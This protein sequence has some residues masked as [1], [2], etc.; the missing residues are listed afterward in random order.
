MTDVLGH[1]FTTASKVGSRN[2]KDY[3]ALGGIEGGLQIVKVLTWINDPGEAIPLNRA[4]DK[5]IAMSF[6][7]PG[8]ESSVQV[9]GRAMKQLTCSIIQTVLLSG[10]L[11]ILSVHFTVGH[12]QDRPKNMKT[13]V[14]CGNQIKQQCS[15][16]PVQANNLLECIQRSQEKMSPKCAALALNVVRL[17]DSDANRLCKGVVASQGNILGCLT[18]ANNRVSTRCSAALDAASL[19]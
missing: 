7:R 17:C 16:V 5:C 15:G 13:A 11:L 6:G 18:M 2:P 4:R 9:G 14:A 10:T 12:A 3:W 8:R 1:A 19:R